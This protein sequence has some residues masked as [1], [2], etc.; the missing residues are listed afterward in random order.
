MALGA[1]LQKRDDAY[2][3]IVN[4]P[5]ELLKLRFQKF[6]VV[7]FHHF[8]DARL[9]RD[10]PAGNCVRDNID[11]AD[12]NLA[13][14]AE[15]TALVDRAKERVDLIDERRRQSHTGRITREDRKSVV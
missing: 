2:S 8:G 10:E 14:F 13:A 15:V 6:V 5:T 1:L 11:F 3:R 7:P 4:T 9:Q 12:A